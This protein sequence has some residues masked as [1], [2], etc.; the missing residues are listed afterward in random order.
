VLQD[1]L[2]QTKAYIVG[3]SHRILKIRLKNVF[4]KMIK[5]VITA[6]CISQV[7]QV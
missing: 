2:E 3:H 5:H 1:K 6:V 4:T 7:R